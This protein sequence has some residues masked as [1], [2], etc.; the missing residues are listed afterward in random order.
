M[1]RITT[2]LGLVVL[3]LASFR[4]AAADGHIFACA[5]YTGGK[6][7]LVGADGAVT[8]EHPAAHCN[9]FWVLANGNLLFTT[10]HGVLEVTREKK[11]VFKYESKS[12]IYAC[13]RLPN[14]N[15]FV[16]ECNAG[17][18]LEVSSAGKVV[19]EIRLLPE[20]KD[21]GHSYIRNAR[22]LPNGNFL[23][24]HY[25]EQIVREYDAKGKVVREFK[26]PS[27][28]HSAIRLPNGNTLITL[29]DKIKEPGLIEYDADGKVVWQLS[30]KDL[31]GAPL[32]FVAGLHRLANGNT[33]LCNWLGHGNLGKAPHLFEVTPDKKV[34]WSYANHKDM[35]T[36]ASVIMLDKPADPL[37]GEVQ[38]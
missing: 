4:T 6:V 11:V 1:K 22:E 17:R 36:I 25:G 5:D 31:P 2:W 15:T 16:G 13:Q 35:K 24:T 20:G 34:V 32:K 27:S 9:D 30:N 18:M 23:V 29:A 21:G 26:A 37:K 19:R 10:G 7:F 28:P 3:A 12:E 33:V 8:W 38:H 14:G